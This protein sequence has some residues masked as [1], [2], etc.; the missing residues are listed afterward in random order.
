VARAS[1]PGAGDVAAAER[2]VKLTTEKKILFNSALWTPGK[3]IPLPPQGQR[4]VWKG[5]RILLS[6]SLELTAGRRE[7]VQVGIVRAR[8]VVVEYE[9][10]GGD[11]DAEEEAGLLDQAD[12]LITRYRSGVAYANVSGSK[13]V[14]LVSTG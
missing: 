4:D 6:P 5:R 14:C 7:A 9:R 13:C 11:G 1:L 3:E 10:V 8:G 2:K 12:V